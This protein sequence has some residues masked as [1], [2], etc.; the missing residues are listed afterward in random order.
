MAGS[1]RDQ[2]VATG[3]VTR[4]QANKA[5]AQSRKRNKKR[6]QP[7]NDISKEVAKAEAAKREKDKALNQALEE[8]AKKAELK[9]QIKQLIE[10]NCAKKIKGEVTHNYESGGRIR[11]L[12]TTD[13]YRKKLIAGS[14][15]ITRLNGVTHL[16]PPEIGHKVIE[17]NPDY[18]VVFNKNDEKPSEDDPYAEYQV[19]D[20]LTW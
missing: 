13:E 6:R 7:E 12:F 5:N 8:K 11:Q 10:S 19:P 17:L 3:L 20:D 1:L 4:E 16:I 2:L 18:L 15:V 9:Q 14:L